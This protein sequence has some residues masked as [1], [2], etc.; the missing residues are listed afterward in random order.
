[1]K[2]NQTLRL[3][4]LNFF[5]ESER[6]ENQNLNVRSSNDSIILDLP[7]SYSS[8]KCCINCFKNNLY[9]KL[10]VI[11]SE[12][13][14]QPMISKKRLDLIVSF[15]NEVKMDSKSVKDLISSLIEAAK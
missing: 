5:I 2:Q 11:P 1:M 6:I 4:I 3:Q 13:R 8:H 14:V 12:A 9:V 10:H 7:K 15:K